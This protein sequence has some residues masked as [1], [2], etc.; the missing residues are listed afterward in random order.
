[1][2]HSFK[3]PVLLGLSAC[4][5]LTLG[6]LASCNFGGNAA[7]AQIETAPAPAAATATKPNFIMIV[8]DDLGYGD[9]SLT[10]S[11]QIPTPNIDR[12]AKTGTFFSQGYVSSSVCSPSR[13][14]FITGI[15]GVEMGYDNNITIWAARGPATMAAF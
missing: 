8:A 2:K 15:N 14:G 12:L 11:T 1:M 4:S 3:R 10:G 9:L 5:A 13:A 6:V 7:L